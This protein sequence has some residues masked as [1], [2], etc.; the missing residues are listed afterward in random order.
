MTR[1][2]KHGLHGKNTT[3]KDRIFGEKIAE[4]KTVGCFNPYPA[5]AG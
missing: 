3:L 5:V 2:R 1:N 4:E